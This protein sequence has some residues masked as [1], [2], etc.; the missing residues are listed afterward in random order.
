MAL[1]ICTGESFYSR[2]ARMATSSTSSF[3]ILE[4]I[5]DEGLSRRTVLPSLGR[6]LRFHVKAII[7]LQDAL[8]VF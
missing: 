7:I 2:R 4:L 5:V 8:A 3:Y 6:P 1:A